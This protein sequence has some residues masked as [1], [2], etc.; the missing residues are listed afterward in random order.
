MIERL[1]NIEK[2][3]NEIMEEIT[4]PEVLGDIKK[5]ME[6]SKEQS[7][8]RENYEAYQEYKKVLEDKNKI[9]YG[10]LPAGAS[11]GE[12][13]HTDN[14]EMFYAIEDY[15]SNFAIQP[16]QEKIIFTSLSRPIIPAP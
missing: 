10:T 8:L 13:T 6:L 1:E 14:C 4:K 9:M 7:S 12:H 15:H 5:T 16:L 11:I 3:Y 2:R